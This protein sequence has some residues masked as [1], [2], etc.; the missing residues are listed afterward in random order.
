MGLGMNYFTRVSVAVLLFALP[1]TVQ[2]L[3]TRLPYYG[4][5]LYEAVADGASNR[6]LV[7]KLNK[8]LKSSHVPIGYDHAKVQLLSKYYP[9]ATGKGYT[10]VDVYCE[11]EYPV[12]GPSALPANEMLNIEHTWPQS[13]FTNRYPTHVQKADMHHLFPSDSQLNSTR[14]NFPFGEVNVRK[15]N[16][17]CDSSKFGYARNDSRLVFEPPQNHRGNVARA[18]FYF[19]VRYETDIPDF[20]EAFLRKWHD[21]D[22][23]D[24]EEMARNEMIFK[25]QKDRNPFIDHPEL[26]DKISNF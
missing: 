16:L 3:L 20:E 1:L 17:K 11:K 19:S 18:L 6:A 5:A 8:L 7:I 14:G 10:I 12:P 2:A 13:H 9:V 24:Q 21:E 22:P 23:I 26:V 15:T 25:V 4:E